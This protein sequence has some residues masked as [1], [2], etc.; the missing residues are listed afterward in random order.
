MLMLL[1]WPQ[2]WYSKVVKNFLQKHERLICILAPT[3]FGVLYI[4]LCSINLQQSIWFDESYGAY[5]TRFSFEDI[6]GLTAADVHPP[7]YYFLL[8]LWSGIFGYTDFGM[9][10]MS[11]FFGAIAIVFAWQ[12]LKRTF[13]T[14]PALIA[15][16]L[17]TLSPMLIRYG[18]EMRMY[19]MAVAIIFG[20]TYVLQLAIDTKKRRYW[21]IY[22]ILMA[23][24]MWTHYFVALIWLAHLAYLIYVYRKKIFQ[25]NI[26]ISYALA[27]VLYLPWIPSFLSQTSTVQQGF[28]IGAP[29]IA[30]VTDYFTNSFLY[31]NSADIAG[32][33]LILTVVIAFCFVSLV[34]RLGKKLSLL[35]FMAFLPPILLILLSM[36]PF[37]PMFVDRYIIYSM[38]C[39]SLI[40]GI[41]LTVVKFKSRIVAPIIMT[42]LFVGTSVI[43]IFNVYEFGNY[44]KTTHGKSDA[45]ALF[46]SVAAIS[47]PGEPIIS[48]SEWLYY[49][50]SFYGTPEHPVYFVDEMTTYKWGSHEPLRQHDYGKI[51]DL[52]MFLAKHERVWF[53]GSKPSKSSLNFP[54]DGYSELQVMTLNV[55][56][57]QAPY[58]A[59]EVTRLAPQS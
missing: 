29:S 20:A 10:F 50:L 28:W 41:G 22:G 38:I 4:V 18:Q 43:G 54:R 34:R 31:L 59:I 14:K 46:E 1:I 39:L 7:L 30:T 25:K 33:L 37:T 47:Q 52:D 24:G 49:D 13:G 26:I 42:L 57:D 17:M 6:W 9:R 8:K 53:V 35:H 44:N 36:P 23:L 19:T 16:L 40:V 48:N 3:L 32:W 27:V 12:W 5:L 11:V 2:L 45:K 15:T 55:N 56:I 21:I 51:I 58:Q